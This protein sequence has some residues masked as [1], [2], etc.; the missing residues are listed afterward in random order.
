MSFHNP[1][2]ESMTLLAS[3]APITRRIKLGVAVYLLALRS[4]A[5]A[6]KTAATLD[7]LSGG[8][9]VFGVGV[10]GENP[11]EF[12]LCG[13]PHQE[14]GA[15]VNEAIDV[16]RTLWRDTPATFHGRF[17][18]FE[19]VSIDPKPVQQP[20]ADLD[21]RPLR[22]RAGPRGPAGRR[23]GV[24][25]RAG[26]SLR[27][28]PRQDPRRGGG[29]RP[30]ARR[31]SPPPTSSSSRSGATSRRRSGRGCAC[32]ASGTRRTSGRS[33]SATASSARPS[34]ARSSSR[35]P[36]RRLQLLPHE[37]DRR[38][39]GRA[40]A[41]R[42]DRRR[43]HSALPRPV[44]RG[45]AAARVPGRGHRGPQSQSRC[46][47]G[48]SAHGGAARPGLRGG[49]V[50]VGA[51]RPQDRARLQHG[52]APG[53]GRRLTLSV[54]VAPGGLGSQWIRGLK[55]GDVVPFKGPT[56]GFVMDRADAR[57][58]VFVAE[59]IG[60]VPI[61]S[62]LFDL[63]DYRLRPAERSHPVGAQSRLAALRGGLPHPH[64]RQQ[65]LLLSAGDA[66][67]AARLAR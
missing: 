27:A 13:I 32:S 1:I 60:V 2:Y 23:L 52:L 19:S 44:G 28:E 40:R 16:V 43:D 65:G 20:P 67:A 6:A 17:T 48:R 8:R 25:R 9:L 61:R 18:R 3:Y 42:D 31:A 66:A 45:A 4:P 46:D 59:E 57:R 62:M 7:V 55:P 39:A 29:R 10:G 5:V 38:P 49:A 33:R 22:R 64:P 53:R 58:P 51:V 26:R 63:Y 35:L 36:R 15:R 37:R 24:L 11:K 50:G 21:R 14:R 12:E 56:G 54:D 30:L 34:S 41:A 47:R